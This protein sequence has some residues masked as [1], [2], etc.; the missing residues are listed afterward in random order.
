[1]RSLAYIKLL[2]L[3][4]FIVSSCNFSDYIG[5]GTVGRIQHYDFQYS[6]QELGDRLEYELQTNENI[7]DVDSDKYFDLIAANNND[8][9]DDHLI[10]DRR[11]YYRDFLY[12]SINQKK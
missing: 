7:N 2:F 6:H 5:A 10:E 8:Y 12:L 11:N 3:L 9:K 1:M 4:F